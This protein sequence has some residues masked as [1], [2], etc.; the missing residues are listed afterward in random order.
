MGEAV[1]EVGA[2]ADG[3]ELA[4]FGGEDFARESLGERGIG[5]LEP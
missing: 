4:F 3:G 5:D 1:T 2:V